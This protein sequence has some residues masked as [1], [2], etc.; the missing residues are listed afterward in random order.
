MIEQSP[1]PLEAEI[2]CLKAKVPSGWPKAT[3][4]PPDIVAEFCD[5]LWKHG[6]Q[7]SSIELSKWANFTPLMVRTGLKAWRLAKGLPEQGFRGD[8]AL[9]TNLEELSRIIAPEI[10][11]AP[12]TAFDPLNDGRW[13]PP[14]LKILSYLGRIENRTVRN[15]MALYALIKSEQEYF[16]VYNVITNFVSAVR[17]IMKENSIDDI[18]DIDPNDLLFRVHRGEAGKALTEHQKK[19]LI[20]QWNRLCYAFEEYLARISEEQRVAL[21]PFVIRGVTDRYKLISHKPWDTW[22]RIRRAKVKEKT[23]AVHSHFH[24]IR[25]FAKARLN[26]V[27][28]LREAFKSAVAYVE[29]NKISPPYKF[30]YK[31]KVID[32]S[33]RTVN[34]TI[35]LTL[36]DDIS[37]FD[38]AISK[39]YSSTRERKLERKRLTGRFANDQRYYEIELNGVESRNVRTVPFWFIELFDLEMFSNTQNA[40]TLRARSEFN[41]RWGYNTKNQWTTKAKVL[42]WRPGRSRLMKFLRD[43][44]SRFIPVEEIYIATL[45]AHLIIRVQTITGARIGE[46]QQIAQNAECI[47]Q[48]VNVGPKAATR[49]VLRLIPK[50]QKERKNFYIDEETKNNL[51]EVIGYLRDLHGTKKIPIIETQYKRT[52][53]DRYIFQTRNTMLHQDTMNVLIRFLLHG[54]VLKGATEGTV[55]ITSHILRHA[56][57]TELADLG[58]RHDVIGEIIHQRDISITKYYSKPTQAQVMNAAEMIFIDRIDVAAEAVRSPEEIKVALQDAEGTVGALA[59]VVGG[60]CV[61]GVSCPVKFA[62]IGCAGNVPDPAKRYQIE[63]KRVW[64]KG[65]AKWAAEEGLKVEERQLKRHV[66]DCELMLREMDLIESVRADEAQKIIL[67]HN[68]GGRDGER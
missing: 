36:W 11:I 12:Q 37:S 48:L 63:R 57:A 35:H 15:V 52:P 67:S 55:H 8:K 54:L 4:L 45:F 5:L 19:T 24:E 13:A 33:G 27:R 18:S 60:T 66:E 68:P 49:W 1:Q 20:G 28:R 31:E 59:E 2:E 56:F 42:T 21:S 43:K 65:Q 46:V 10:T 26:Q 38:L 7:P 6:I 34:Q 32:E 62:C 39:G 29:E 61:V 58:V 40:E 9:P 22:D 17:V 47:K 23:D 14:A 16:P 44:G 50:G 3:P 25:F 53:P 41:Q 64:A 51:L 30:S